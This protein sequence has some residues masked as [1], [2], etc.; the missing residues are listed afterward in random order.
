M[1]AVSARSTRGA[2]RTLRKACARAAAI[3][4]SAKPPSGPTRITTASAEAGRSVSGTSRSPSHALEARLVLRPGGVEDEE[5]LAGP[6]AVRAQ[7]AQVGAAQ[8]EPRSLGP[9]VRHEEAEH[10]RAP[11]PG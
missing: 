8:A 11:S 6:H 1:A 7:V 4:S 3:S 5:A 2:R 10:L 9:R